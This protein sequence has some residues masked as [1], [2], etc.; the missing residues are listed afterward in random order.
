MVEI[1]ALRAEAWTNV[2]IAGLAAFDGKADCSDQGVIP[3][4]TGKR[5]VWN[6]PSEK[7]LLQ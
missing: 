2:P 6:D 4:I 7:P 3:V 1:D 5:W